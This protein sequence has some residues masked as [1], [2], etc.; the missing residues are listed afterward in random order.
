MRTIAVLSA[1][2]AILGLG[3]RP[4]P[5]T[6]SRPRLPRETLPALIVGLL[7]G[8][9]VAGLGAPTAIAG[10]TGVLV[11]PVPFMASRVRSSRVASRAAARWPDFLAAIRS[12]IAAGGSLP[13]ATAAAAAHLGGRYL[14]LTRGP[15]VPFTQAMAD[16]RE[17]WADPL[18]DRI[19]TTLTVAA[20][21]GGRQV[22][23][24]LSALS[25]SVGDELRLRRAHDAALTEQRLTA[26]VALV[27]P[28]AM[29]AL[30]VATNPT[31]SQSFSSPTGS[32]IVVVGLVATVAGYA[33][34]RRAAR[35]SQPPR[36][37]R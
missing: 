5:V 34:A 25:T 27:A 20:E 10:A 24:V 17:A 6:L 37:F 29:L 26:G 7:G 28:W 31:A 14:D 2:G 35:L 21:I 33:L 13:D 32:L 16:T 1:G 22:D 4:I 23:A 3:S 8:V 18:A 11:A 36:L 9:V 30:S 15:G 19:L 12:R